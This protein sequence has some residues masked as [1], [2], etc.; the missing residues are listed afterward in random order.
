MNDYTNQALGM[1]TLSERA[2]NET[3][4]R[5][6]ESGRF[7]SHAVTQQ[8]NQIITTLLAP[9][10]IGIANLNADPNPT[11][12]MELTMDMHMVFGSAHLA[13]PNTNPWVSNPRSIRWAP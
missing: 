4:A 9:P 5:E 12:R 13:V 11:I 6:W 8:G 10:R 1:M 3:L 2:I 7:G